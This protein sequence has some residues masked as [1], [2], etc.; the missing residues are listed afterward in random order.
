MYF[1]FSI[2]LNGDINA[3][4]KLDENFK[5]MQMATLINAFHLMS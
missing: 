3:E 5:E 4:R 2:G 1:C